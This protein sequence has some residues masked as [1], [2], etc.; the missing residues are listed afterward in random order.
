MIFTARTCTSPVNS[1]E[2]TGQPETLYQ[3]R[4]ILPLPPWWFA[5]SQ[6]D[7][8]ELD[9]WI[10]EVEKAVFT[11]DVT[12]AELLTPVRPEMKSGSKLFS[13]LRDKQL[14]KTIPLNVEGGDL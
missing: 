12:A 10:E 9:K 2:P 7:F 6:G 4:L 14:C 1:I 5:A 8:E 11:A 13:R 3:N